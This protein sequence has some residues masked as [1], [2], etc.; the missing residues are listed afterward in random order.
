RLRFELER[1][2]VKLAGEL[3]RRIVAIFQHRDSGA[4]VLTDI[5]G[6]VLRERDWGTML[7]GFPVRFLAV[8]IQHTRPALPQART[9]R[10]EV[11]ND[12]VL[13]GAQLWPRPNR[14]LEIEQVV[15]EH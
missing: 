14:A 13:A 9:I 7:D 8:H 2:L 10:L 11:E 15:E 12:G 5:K 3:E 6:F 1:Q 4:G